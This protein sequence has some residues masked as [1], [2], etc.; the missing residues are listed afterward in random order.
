MGE[1]TSYTP[2]TFCWVDLMA[3]DQDAAKRYYTDLFGWDYQDFP[4]GEG[5]LYSLA[6]VDGTPVAAI[7]PLPDEGVPPHWN[8]YVSVDDADAAAARAQELGATVI[9]AA[10]D[11]GEYGRVAMIQ[12]PQGAILGLWQPGAH[13]GAGLVNAPGALS[14]NDLL[15]PDVEASATFYRELFGWEISEIPAAD[16]QYWSIANGEIKNG[17]LMA[18]PPGGHPAWNLYFA[19]EDADATLARAAELGGEA[20]MGPMDVPGGRFAIIRDPQNAVFSIVDGELD[21]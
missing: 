20:L 7:T 17:G 12:D 16:G 13:I 9:V 14:W 8:C 3:A 6:Q 18:V 4:L 10:G 19:V 15:S 1:R 11:V 21:P 5:T 2:G